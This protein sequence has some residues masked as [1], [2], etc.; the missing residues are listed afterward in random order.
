MTTTPDQWDELS[1]RLK[2]FITEATNASFQCGAWEGESKEEYE[3]YLVISN[4]T[5]TDLLAAIAAELRKLGKEINRLQ[6]ELTVIGDMG[7]T[8]WNDN[9][10]G[11]VANAVPE[12]PKTY[13]EHRRAEIEQ[14]QAMRQRIAELEALLKRL[15]E[16]DHLDGSADGP[17]W[18]GQI[19]AALE[20]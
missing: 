1:E 6:Y 7:V 8:D 2:P 3:Q 4:K 9:V 17:Y 20:E 11:L 10:V 13:A 19:D 15:L 18:R 16:W 14:A 12:P 5:K